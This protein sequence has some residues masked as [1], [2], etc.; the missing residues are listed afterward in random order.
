M[1]HSR[2]LMLTLA[3]TTGVTTTGCPRSASLVPPDPIPQR[4]VYVPPLNVRPTP[5]PV[6]RREP[7]PGGNPW[8]PE[9]PAR[10]W[11]SIVIHHT[12][13]NR[14]SVESIHAAHLKRKDA[15]GR[16]WR[17]VGYHFVIGN[18]NGMGD[19]E[20]E[21]TFRWR[22][23]IPGAHAGS[24]E[25]NDHG[26]GIAL[27][28]NFEQ[29]RPT[30]AQ[31]AAV[32]RLVGVLKRSYRIPAKSVVGHNSVKAT[33]CPGRYFPLAEVAAAFPVG[34]RASAWLPDASPSRKHT[35]KRE[36]Q[37]DRPARFRPARM[38]LLQ[39]RSTW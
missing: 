35:L 17:G 27:V 21:P 18:G 9:S 32:K 10:H 14:G 31:L 5:P 1:K 2:T 12:A 11:T 16:A 13:T 15:S 30:P 4:P 29:R 39:E 33:A 37:L 24:R 34:V 22:T 19:G 23:Q 20:I 36:L 25:Y 28:G 3:L 26:I 38:V 8:R 7:L 6:T